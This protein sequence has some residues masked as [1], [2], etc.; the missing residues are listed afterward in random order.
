MTRDQRPHVML[1]YG[2]RPEAIKT[3]PLVLGLRARGAVRVSVC[4]TGQ[5]REMLQ[6]VN[7]VFGIVPEHDLELFEPGQGIESIV[8]KTLLRLTPLLAAGNPDRPDAVVVHGD[9][10]TANAA[11]QAAFYAGVPVVHLEAG[12]RTDD[13]ASPF[14]EEAN[15]QLIGRLATLHLAPT[16]RNR[17]ALRAENVPA[18]RIVVTGNT[19]ID[20]LTQVV[21]QLREDAAA[22]GAGGAASEEG[23]GP[24]V[25][26]RVLVTLH[27]RENLG[28]R[29]VGIA[30]AL[31]RVA[32]ESPDVTFVVP[33][34]LN[35][36]VR[37]AVLPEFAGVPTIEVHD[38]LD[39]TFVGELARCA[40]VV[41]DSGG[42]QE[43]GPGLGKPVL[44]A[45]D[46][47]ERPEAVEAGTARLVGT[48][49]E[50]VYAELRRLLDDPAA[51][52]AMATAVNPYGDGAAVPRCAAAIEA[53]LGVGVRARSSGIVRRRRQL[54]TELRR[55][56]RR[57]FP[58]RCAG[59][60]DRSRAA[61][62]VAAP[63]GRVGQ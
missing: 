12:L 31:R 25:R 38:P 10:S 48:S 23:A 14:P 2:T 33:L 19:V 16:A 50:N 46:T 7:D 13:L 15:R 59:R 49:E 55:C 30:R 32:L 27:R 18:E 60:A 47:T 35:P 28:E 42:L 36:A 53:M 57:P 20:A 58:P 24:D 11:A 37:R 44:V 41:T 40:I 56:T 3:A 21:A 5:H 43:E 29:M 26:R 4:V 1:V 17:A 6:Q 54:P 22:A 63:Q 9:T 62:T 51:Y 34:H 45:R 8:A 52:E 61:P 39:L